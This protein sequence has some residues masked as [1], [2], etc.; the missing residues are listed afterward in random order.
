MRKVKKEND[1]EL[2]SMFLSLLSKILHGIEDSFVLPKSVS[3]IWRFTKY[4]I[5]YSRGMDKEDWKH[6]SIKSNADTIYINKITDFLAELLIAVFDINNKLNEIRE[7]YKMSSINI[8][9]YAMK[10]RSERELW[11]NQGM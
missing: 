8:A 3:D 11:K 1:Y 2:L 10:Q 4:S 9:E 5:E 6:V 7:G